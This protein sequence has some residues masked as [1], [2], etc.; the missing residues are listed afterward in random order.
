MNN[1]R[2]TSVQTVRIGSRGSP[3]AL[4]QARWMASALE[5]ASGGTLSTEIITFTTTGDQLTTERLI[6]SGGKGLFTK[7]ID[8]ALDEGQIDIGVHSLKDVPT[9]LPGGHAL[10]CV[11]PREDPREGFLSPKAAKLADLPKGA[12]LGTASLRREAQTLARRPDL[13]IVTFRG[14]VQ[15]RM[16]KLEEGQAAATYLAMAGLNR[17]GMAHLAKPIALEEMLPSAAQ[18]IIGVTA[19]KGACGAAL[20]HA[21]ADIEDAA[22]RAAAIAER[23]FLAELDGSCRTPIAAHLFDLGDRWRLKGEV[24]SVCGQL[25]W[26]AEMDAPRNAGEDALEQLG[27]ATARIVRKA[28]GD[29]LP[30]FSDT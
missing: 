3:L 4:Y 10:V 1:K 28:A 14:N 12:R 5:K 16:R 25:R 9:E 26:A 27:K 29:Q 21:L 30:A 18:G 7:E 19:L 22:S 2:K 23:A 15:T 6:N 24:L 8:C 17:L 13:E 20:S 11:P